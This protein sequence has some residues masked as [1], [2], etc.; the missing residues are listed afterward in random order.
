MNENSVTLTERTIGGV[1]QALISRAMRLK[2][3][4]DEPI[5]DIGCGTGAWLSRLAD[6][7]YTNLYGVDRDLG[8]VGFGA[9]TYDSVDLDTATHLS[10]KVNSFK[11][12]TAI[13]V[14]EHL[15]NPGN[16]FTLVSRYM[17]PDGYLLVTS[18]NI[19]SIICRLRFLITGKLKQFDDKGDQTHIYP[20]LLTSLERLLPRYNLSIAQRWCFPDNGSSPTTVSRSLRVSGALLRRILPEPMAGDVMCLLITRVRGHD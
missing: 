16:F 15:V 8:S 14:L 5:L 13:E 2:I 3:G 12:I 4:A 19:H 17:S 1:H 10:F 20:V 18:P 11:L 9:A 6:V 7:G